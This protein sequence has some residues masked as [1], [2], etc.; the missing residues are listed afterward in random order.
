[1]AA[2]AAGPL[3][4][5]CSVKWTLSVPCMNVSSLLVAQINEWETEDC[6]G[7]SQKCLYSIVAVGDNELLATHTTPLM[8]FVDDIKFTF[9][10]REKD[11]CEVLGQSV[12]RSWY[13]ILDSGTNYCNMYNLMNGSGLRLTP[14]FN[15]YTSDSN[16]TQYSTAKL[17][18]DE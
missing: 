4:A 2:L 12:S 11:N 9:N 10:S 16:C 18:L 8:K 6:P 17:Y 15:E 13:A 14:G 7:K 1:M 3:H 5:Q